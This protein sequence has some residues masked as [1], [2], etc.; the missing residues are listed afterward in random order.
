[1]RR[2]LKQSFLEDLSSSN[3]S[4]ACLCVRDKKEEGGDTRR[5]RVSSLFFRPERLL[6]HLSRS[7]EKRLKEKREGG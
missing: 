4:A 1:M 6:W 2:G 7:E 5:K 3:A